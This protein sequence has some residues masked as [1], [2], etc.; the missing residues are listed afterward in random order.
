MGRVY[1]VDVATTHSTSLAD[2]L[3]I[4]APADAVVVLHYLESMQASDYGDA[5]AE[6]LEYRIV[7]CS[8][9]GSGGATET[10]Q[11]LSAGDPAF[12]GTVES[13][14]T[15]AAIGST[16]LYVSAFNVQLGVIF[17]PVKK[18]IISPG[19]RLVFRVSGASDALSLFTTAVFEEI[20]G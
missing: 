11:A 16:N 4:N 6:G 14:N 19:E 13:N 20:G 9:S 3:E 8:S 17:D 7:R 1:T 5:E 2:V 15:S 18:P 12:G 10:A